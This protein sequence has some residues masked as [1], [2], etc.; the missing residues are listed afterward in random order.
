MRGL[1]REMKIIYTLNRKGK[2]KL[3]VIILFST[4]LHFIYLKLILKKKIILTMK[5]HFNAFRITLWNYCYIHT[6]ITKIII[7]FSTIMHS[8]YRKFKIK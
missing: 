8:I 4:I 2:Q 6:V 7:L 5:L 3:V 1:Q